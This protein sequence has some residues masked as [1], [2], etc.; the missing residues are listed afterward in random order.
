MNGC[1][2]KSA[3]FLNWREDGADTSVCSGILLKND[4]T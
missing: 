2:C 1:N 4:D 3:E